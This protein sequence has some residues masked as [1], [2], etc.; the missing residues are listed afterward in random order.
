MISA[1]VQ[2]NAFSFAALNMVPKR[3]PHCP[4]A[5]LLSFMD[6]TVT[7][8]CVCLAFVRLSGRLCLG[9]GHLQVHPNAINSIPLHVHMEIGEQCGTPG[10]KQD[11][12]ACT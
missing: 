2:G 1:H 10:G 4:G 7:V 11:G 12:A 8:V 9:P 3:Q 5:P 6:G